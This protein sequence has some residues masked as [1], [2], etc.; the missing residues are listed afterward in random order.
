MGTGNTNLPEDQR[1]Q[2]EAAARAENRTADELVSEAVERFMDERKWQN[3]VNKAT[4]RNE[5]AG[6]SEAHVATAIEEVRAEHR[7]RN[8]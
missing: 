5:K 8:R 4:K 2:V 1:A 6:R 3:I 7:T